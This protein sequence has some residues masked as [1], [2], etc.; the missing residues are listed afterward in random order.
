MD[1]LSQYTKSQLMGMLHTAS[2]LFDVVFQERRIAYSFIKNLADGCY[3]LA[4]MKIDRLYLSDDLKDS[5]R[6]MLKILEAVT[7]QGGI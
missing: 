6:K 4:E 5:L 2:D 1:S 7:P 3:N